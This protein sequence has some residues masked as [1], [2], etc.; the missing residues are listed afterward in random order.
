MTTG[1]RQDVIGRTCFKADTER[2]QQ[3]RRLTRAALTWP[4]G[5]QLICAYMILTGGGGGEEEECQIEAYTLTD[6][7]PV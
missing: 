5:S 1:R 3:V 6:R 2:R 4:V 7:K